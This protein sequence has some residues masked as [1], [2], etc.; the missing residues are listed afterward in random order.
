MLTSSLVKKFIVPM[1]LNPKFSKELTVVTDGIDQ[2]YAVDEEAKKFGFPVGISAE[3]LNFRVCKLLASPRQWKLDSKMRLGKKCDM[4][5]EC[6]QFEDDTEE[7]NFSIDVCGEADLVQVR[8]HAQDV[9][10]RKQL[11][12]R[13]YAPVK[14]LSD[15]WTLEVV[16]CPFDC[17]VIG[18]TIVQL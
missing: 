12:L 1:L 6:T 18:W 10:Q 8:Q 3:E 14:P 9:A 5:F 17:N 16:T 13:V 4:H 2:Q 7:W 15:M 11:L